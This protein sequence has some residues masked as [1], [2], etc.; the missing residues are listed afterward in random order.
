M[1]KVAELTAAAAATAA[2][3]PTAPTMPTTPEAP[4]FLV[5]Q[6][7]VVKSSSSQSI[8]LPNGTTVS[9]H[10][11]FVC[12]PLQVKL[13]SQKSKHTRDRKWPIRFGTSNFLVQIGKTAARHM[14]METGN[15]KAAP[16]VSLMASQSS[17]VA[18]SVQ[19]HSTLQEQQASLTSQSDVLAIANAAT[20]KTNTVLEQ[21]LRKGAARTSELEQQVEQ[22]SSKV[23]NL[24]D[25]LTT[26]KKQR[27]DDAAQQRHEA[28]PDLLHTKPGYNFNEPALALFAKDVE[29]AE[30][31]VK[32]LAAME[33]SERP[34]AR[35]FVIGTKDVTSKWY[36]PCMTVLSAG[37]RCD[38]DYDCGVYTSQDFSPFTPVVYANDFRKALIEIEKWDFDASA[39]DIWDE[40]MKF[41]VGAGGAG[42]LFTGGAL[43]D[44]LGGT[45]GTHR[46]ASLSKIQKVLYQY[47][48]RSRGTNGAASFASRDFRRLLNPSAAR[49]NVQ[50][51]G[52]HLRPGIRTPDYNKQLVLK[53]NEGPISVEELFRIDLCKKTGLALLGRSDALMSELAFGA[54]QDAQVKGA[55][56]S[57]GVVEYVGKASKVIEQENQLGSDFV[58]QVADGAEE[59]LCSYNTDGKW[60]GHDEPIGDPVLRIFRA[61]FT[62]GSDSSVVGNMIMPIDR[63]LRGTYGEQWKTTGR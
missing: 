12:V 60:Q 13:E 46:T 16:A 49:G 33:E 50:L 5:W 34:D 14:Y 57:A 6:D 61:D 3:A 20:L 37:A 54:A 63:H 58:V 52:A 18:S 15:Y 28:P 30:E 55:M 42:P 62:L 56:S 44:A 19:L 32:K 27:Q 7:L 23:F 4:E 17:Q 9:A 43:K 53:Q 39:E 21:Q 25:S 1:A 51:V 11:L 59:V 35:V 24:L 48:S 36:C 47:A 29:E 8:M 2:T 41:K 22:Q 26:M 45:S 10:A 38:D 40:I 31:T